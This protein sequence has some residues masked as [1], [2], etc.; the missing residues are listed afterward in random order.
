M[1]KVTIKM[2]VMPP[3]AV[4]RAADPARKFLPAEGGT[5]MKKTI[6]S[7][8]CVLA[9]CL[10]LLPTAAL[11]DAEGAPDMLSVGNQVLGSSP[12][13][14]T[15]DSETGDLTEYTEGGDAW[16]VQYN[17]E[18]ATLTLKNATI[19]TTH[20]NSQGAVIYAQSAANSA[21]SLTIELEGRN[22]IECASAF[23]GIYVNA[24]RSV[25]SYGTSASLTITG[26]G[27][28]DVSGSSCGI[29]VKSG[30]GD[31]SLTINEASVNANA[32][33]S[34]GNNHGV[35][36]MSSTH[37]TSSPALSLAVNGGSLTTS[38]SA[39][40][41]GIQFYVGDPGAT[42]A[43]T[44]LTISDN[45]IVDARTGGI[46]ADGASGNP[47]V[48][49][50]STG[51]T[52][53]IVF[54]GK[55]GT[56]YG[57]VTLD[58]SLTI[59]QGETATLTATVTPSDATNK[60]VTWSSNAETVATVTQDPKDGTK[61]TVTALKAGEAT[62]TVTTQDG[63]QKSA[64][65]TVKVEPK[66]YQI[67]ID[68]STLDFGSMF[69]GNSVPGAQAVN[70]KNTGNQNVTVALPASTYYNV[71]AGTGFTDGNAVIEPGKTATFTVQP[72]TGLAAGTYQE[73]LTV[74][75]GNGAQAA[76]L[77]KL[78]VTAKT[79]SMSIDPGA[80][81][82]GNVQ[83]G[84]N[85]PAVKEVV[86]KNTGNQTLTLTQP[87][88]NNYQ[89]GSLNQFT[90]APGDTAIF[91]VQPKAGLLTGTYNETVVVAASGAQSVSVSL[92]FSVGSP[93]TSGT[94]TTEK[95]TLHFDT[96]GGLPLDDVVRGL[97]APVELWPYTPV[98]A[99]YLFQGWFSDQALTK[100][101]SSVVLTKDTTIYAKWA[102]DPAA[103]AAQSSS[104]GSGSSGKGSGS[105]S[106]GKGSGSTTVTVTPSPTV[107][108]TPAPTATP[109][110]ELTA[111]PES[112]A[113][114]ETDA[115]AASFPV[116]PVAAGVI[117]LVVLVGG[118][119]IFR[120]F[121]D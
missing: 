75:G 1:L 76:L 11:A 50:G 110:P 69:A 48:N 24:E 107:T 45:A 109:T 54:D 119:V 40:G 23:Y 39:N 100:A 13:Y 98:R 55:S 77:C 22:T 10:G 111:T 72:K 104:S 63:S 30:S 86:V 83:V 52:G 37:A 97:G 79:Y 46:S 41:K 73:T 14:W 28:L 20:N 25:I 44:S 61:A 82:F 99:G 85:Q 81:G 33:A 26:E 38:G 9:L 59:A 116:I 34:Y 96:N 66:T 88:A 91:T 74:S 5:R 94:A 16:N 18:T 105:G 7:L 87:T 62:I 65:C 64:S 115:N 6:L 78:T 106:S 118:I 117:V 121:R 15:T 67:S 49:V 4:G 113:E 31:A 84:Y 29:Y 17:P 60:A 43:T 2:G 68:Q 19:K 32:T 56:V 114:P 53:G 8:F 51:S 120:R 70:V 103:A 35:Y 108:P 27:S 12:S 95:R 42:N 3:G 89:V 92:T 36:V 58:E 57:D 47:D 71:T 112:S 101:V 21:V 93:V 90:V 102:V 80:I